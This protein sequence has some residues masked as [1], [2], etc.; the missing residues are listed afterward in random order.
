MEK[1]YVYCLVNKMLNDEEYNDFVKMLESQQ[2]ENIIFITRAILSNKILIGVKNKN[3]P[4]LKNDQEDYIF[5][6]RKYFKAFVEIEKFN[7]KEIEEIQTFIK[8]KY[9]PA[10]VVNKNKRIYFNIKDRF[11][12]REIINKKDEQINIKNQQNNVECNF[13]ITP[14]YKQRKHNETNNVQ[15]VE[16]KSTK[17]HIIKPNKQFVNP[18]I[19]DVIVKSKSKN[20]NITIN[21]IIE[22][23]QFQDIISISKINVFDYEFNTFFKIRTT[24]QNVLNKQPKKFIVTVNNNQ[25]NF[26]IDKIQKIEKFK[27]NNKSYKNKQYYQRFEI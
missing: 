26:F 1:F 16:N 11:V 7:N 3:S 25:I 4:I 15:K 21:N 8:F 22:S 12:F 24:D 6:S 27:T 2:N 14:I 10:F 13:L 23:L 5:V 9:S 19:Y 18:I 20:Q 17:L